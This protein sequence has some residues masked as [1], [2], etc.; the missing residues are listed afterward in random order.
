MDILDQI[1]KHADPNIASVT[2]LM[3]SAEDQEQRSLQAGADGF[4][5]KPFQIET[6]VSTIREITED[7]LSENL[8]ERTPER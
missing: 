3:M 5:E 8:G 4:L 7:K 1:R 6:L 2:V